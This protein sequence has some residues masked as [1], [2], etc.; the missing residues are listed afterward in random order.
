MSTSCYET[1]LGINMTD[2]ILGDIPKQARE[3]WLIAKSRLERTMAAMAKSCVSRKFS[4]RKM[5]QHIPNLLRLGS[6]PLYAYTDSDTYIHAGI[7]L[8]A[9]M[10]QC[11]SV[12]IAQTAQRWPL[13]CV[14]T[15]PK[16]VQDI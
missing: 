9:M 10:A 12:G 8:N 2:L 13:S 7:I 11:G 14:G 16:D 6:R 1:L 3:C 4:Q 5:K 15:I